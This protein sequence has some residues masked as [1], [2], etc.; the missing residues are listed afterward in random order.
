MS[1]FQL[2]CG[3]RTS[4]AEKLITIFDMVYTGKYFSY[5]KSIGL[6]YKS[7]MHSLKNFNIIFVVLS[8]NICSC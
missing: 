5:S 1:E 4:M 8:K 3:L 6:I 7:S 2:H